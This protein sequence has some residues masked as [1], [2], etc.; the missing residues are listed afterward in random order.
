MPRPNG[1]IALGRNSDENNNA[2]GGLGALF[3]KKIGFFGMVGATMAAL[4]LKEHWDECMCYGH[5][6]FSLL[7]FF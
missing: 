5:M 1:A 3:S 6:S 4:K 7:K 2:G